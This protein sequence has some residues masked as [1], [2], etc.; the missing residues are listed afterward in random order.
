VGANDSL[1]VADATLLLLLML[2]AVT[3][4]VADWEGVK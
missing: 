2:L 1:A 4:G 3:E